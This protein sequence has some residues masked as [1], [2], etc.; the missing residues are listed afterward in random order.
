MKKA[1]LT[2]IAIALSLA[3]A[4]PSFAAEKTSKKQDAASQTV[5]KPKKPTGSGLVTPNGGA[6]ALTSQECTGIG[7]TVAGNINCLPHKACFTVD[8]A[9]VVRKVCLTQN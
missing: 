8:P 1:F 9:G 3:I 6:I 4:A 7:G 5:K 2:S